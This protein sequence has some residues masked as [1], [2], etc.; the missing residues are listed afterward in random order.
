MQGLD[1]PEVQPGVLLPHVGDG[2]GQAAAVRAGLHEARL[3]RDVHVRQRLGEKIPRHPRPCRCPW[4]TFSTSLFLPAF[5]LSDLFL[6]IISAPTGFHDWGFVTRWAQ[7]LITSNYYLPSTP[8]E[9]YDE[10]RA[11][12]E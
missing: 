12:R 11:A 8:K 7:L 3:Q 2:Q 9:E 1:L 5:L 6:P 10:G 4:M